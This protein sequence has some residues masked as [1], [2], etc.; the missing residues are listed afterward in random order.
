MSSRGELRRSRDEYAHNLAF[1]R[2]VPLNIVQVDPF[3]ADEAT[4]RVMN[5]LSPAPPQAMPGSVRHT[6]QRSHPQAEAVGDATLRLL[7]NPHHPAFP[8]VLPH[9]DA[10]GPPEKAK[11]AST[12]R[13]RA[14]LER[15]LP[16][17][18]R[19]AA[20]VCY[21]SALT[22]VPGRHR[23]LDAAP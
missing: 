3:L 18:L 11:D 15:S 8:S 16:Y 20:P 21:A 14:S 7:L 6:R 17:R 22:G 9:E 10:R 5:A 19:P 4:R 13:E 23:H 2:E 12:D 1:G